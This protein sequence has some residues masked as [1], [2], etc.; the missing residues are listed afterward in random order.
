MTDLQ[1]FPHRIS[2]LGEYDFVLLNERDT[3][4]RRYGVVVYPSHDE[5]YVDL[6]GGGY[7]LFSVPAH[8][9]GKIRRLRDG[10]VLSPLVI[11]ANNIQ[12]SSG[13]FSTSISR[14]FEER[15][16]DIDLLKNLAFV[17][18]VLFDDG[19]IGIPSATTPTTGVGT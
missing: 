16:L 12:R 17:E 5:L 9:E 13:D 11:M 3:S 19:R 4:G 14:S 6:D 7:S 1:A 15:G 2:K 10:S 8:S 18:K